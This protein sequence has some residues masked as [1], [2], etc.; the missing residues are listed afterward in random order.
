MPTIDHSMKKFGMFHVGDRTFHE[1]MERFILGGRRQMFRLE[2]RQTI[3]VHIDSA[4]Q[5]GASR[6]QESR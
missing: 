6:K 1:K 3:V 2:D 4:R 5:A